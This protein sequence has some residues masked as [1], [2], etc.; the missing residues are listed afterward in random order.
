M[1]ADAQRFAE[2]CDAGDRR[3]IGQKSLNVFYSTGTLSEDDIEHL[4]GIVR[5]WDVEQ[6]SMIDVFCRV[7]K[8]I[9]SYC[10]KFMYMCSCTHTAHYV[11][12][13][14]TPLVQ[15]DIDWLWED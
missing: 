1:A 9:F 8:K 4:N 5:Q 10:T 11:H 15:Y 13:T 3:I 6:V 14:T 2:G 12:P 7:L